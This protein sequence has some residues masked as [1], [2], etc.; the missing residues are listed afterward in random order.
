M[1][2]RRVAAVVLPHLLSELA[3]RASPPQHAAHPPPTAVVLLPPDRA[4]LPPELQLTAQTRIDAV[5]LCARRLGLREGLSVAEAHAFVASL[6]I[7]T[8]SMQRVQESLTHLADVLSAF[9]PTVALAPPDTLHLDLTGASHLAGGEQQLCEEVL[10]RVGRIGHAARV[11]VA[12]GPS[13]AQAVAR[14]GA[15]P[16]RVVPPGQDAR[17]LQTLPVTALPIDEDLACW[18]VRLGMMTIGD[19]AR[20]PRAQLASRLGQDAPRILGLI[21][22]V[23]ETPLNAYEAP[24]VMQEEQTWDDGV[25]HLSALVFVVKRLVTNLAARLEGRALATTALEL[26]LLLDR[27]IA[28][29]RGVDDRLSFR[30]DLPTPLYRVDDLMRAL[31]TRLERCELAA[32]AVGVSLL[33]PG[34]VRA[35]RLQLDLSRDVT[36][37]PD[38]LAVL[39][40]ELSAEIGADR[41]GTLRIEASL[42]PEARSSLVPITS[43]LSR[44]APGRPVPGPGTSITR[45]L[46]APIPLG[47]ARIAI[48]AALHGLHPL[49]FQVDRIVFD[50]RLRGVQ[51]W[52]PSP[53]D[54]DY[55]HLWLRTGVAPSGACAWC[56][57][58]RHHNQLM[59]HGWQT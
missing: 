46:P 15:S 17:W 57:V 33:A 8:I 38:A 25:E 9:A 54:R 3:A 23:D 27:S 49:V 18:L 35:P 59:L 21:D 28:R 48:H 42:R 20:L 10:D 24:L 22:G 36:T 51:W 14:H 11:A 53:V 40:A 32:P 7:R 6:V 16:V 4:S 58:D 39:L 55:L 19:L 56:Y 1:L 13:I 5:D 26:H 29:L 44:P 41:V 45:L 43:T 2:P 12:S 47:P 30:L 37:S 34:I 50:T 31:R 52:T